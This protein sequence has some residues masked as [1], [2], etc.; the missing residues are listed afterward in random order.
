METAA[1]MSALVPASPSPL[2]TEL[3]AL[4]E[5]AHGYAADA[6]AGSTRRIY[7]GKFRAF[8]AWCRARALAALPAH[9]ATVVLY[10]TD[11]ANA[12]RSVKT[13]EVAVAGIAFVHREAG[14]AWKASDALREVMSGI[15]R[16]VGVGAKQR[17]AAL[18]GGHLRTV[19]APLGASLADLRDRALLTVGWWGAF[20]RAVLASLHV[21]HLT[22]VPEGLL[23]TVERDKRDQEGRGH[24]VPL[25]FAASPEVCP[26]RAL[27]AWRDAAGITRGPLF[28]SVDHGIV[29][30]DAICARTVARIVKRAAERVGLDPA[31]LGG[32]SLRAGFVTTAARQGHALEAIMRHTGHEDERVARAY[33]RM[34]T[35]FHGSVAKAVT[36]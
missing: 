13:I 35:A 21:R 1:S 19:L 23:V 4:A 25:P 36:I 24:L 17:K 32:H 20:R 29:A 18:E 30:P 31:V 15:R 3:A 34:A 6:R 27:R 26:V 11:C 10:V 2:T 9:P 33:V 5:D 14:H 7:R 22:E 8:E 12:G 28:R 16:R